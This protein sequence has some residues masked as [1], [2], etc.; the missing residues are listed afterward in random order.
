MLKFALDHTLLFWN[1][2]I[3]YTYIP[4]NA[5]SS[6]RLTIA[7]A[8]GLI[9]SKNEHKFIHL[10]NDTF[11]PSLK[12]AFT[13]TSSF[14]VLRDPVE[15]VQSV[16]IDK[17]LSKENAAMIFCQ[18][19]KILIDDLT[20]KEFCTRLCTDINCLYLNPHWIPQNKFLL[21]KKESYTKIFNFNQLTD[22][23]DWLKELNVKFED[24]R[25]LTQHGTDT[26]ERKAIS[27]AHNKTIKELAELKKQG[28]IP[29]KKDM[30][31]EEIIRLIKNAYSDDYTLLDM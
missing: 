12:D 23:N 6:L 1:E 22:L 8:N 25:P 9:S 11:V 26:F 16:F 31:D 14:V 30:I 19:Q 20:F 3:S 21:F 5:C 10:N 28:I 13:S 4:K 29:A 18:H 17:F 27:G 24:A 15:R 7:I 2:N